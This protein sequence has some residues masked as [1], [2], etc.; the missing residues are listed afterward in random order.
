MKI[1]VGDLVRWVGPGF[2]PGTLGVIKRMQRIHKKI[3]DRFGVVLEVGGKEEYFKRSGEIKEI[4]C[5][6]A[7]GN[8]ILILSHTHLEVINER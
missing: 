2:S 8:D 7:F 1:K 3:G 5:R 6:V 4:P